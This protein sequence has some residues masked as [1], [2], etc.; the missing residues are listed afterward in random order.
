M[1]HDRSNRDH[2]HPLEH[3]TPFRGNFLRETPQA[4]LDLLENTSLFTEDEQ[5]DILS[6]SSPID[7]YDVGT[8]IEGGKWVDRF[9]EISK[10]EDLSPEG[11]RL[12]LRAAD[13]IE[14]GFASL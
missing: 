12:L 3:L 1:G 10:R 9:R 4:V 13:S 5:E 2:G 8:L 7:D 14:T 6:A 11:V